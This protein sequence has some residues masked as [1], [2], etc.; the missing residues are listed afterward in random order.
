MT[1]HCFYFPPDTDSGVKSEDGSSSAAASTTGGASS[2]T[3][4]AKVGNTIGQ[5]QG[6]TREKGGAAEQTSF[7]RNLRDILNGAVSRPP[8]KFSSFPIF[9]PP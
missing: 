2:S 4:L 6:R 9:H 5:L 8:L 1:L 3:S 7:S